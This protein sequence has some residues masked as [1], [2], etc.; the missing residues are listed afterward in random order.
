MR[1]VVIAFLLGGVAVA[2]ALLAAG[3]ALGVA[4]DAAGWGDFEIGIGAIV[5]LA[6]ERN[7]GGSSTTFGTGILLAAAAGGVL[8]ALAAAFLARRPG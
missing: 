6:F 1:T 5:L 3:F 8:N 2:L 4:A 7:A